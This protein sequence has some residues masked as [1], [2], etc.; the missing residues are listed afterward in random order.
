MNIADSERNLDPNPTNAPKGSREREA[1]YRWRYDNGCQ[2]FHPDDVDDVS[3]DV[4][5]RGFN[6]P[7][8][9]SERLRARSTIAEPTE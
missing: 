3:E 8:I 2:I 7:G 1:V 6:H 9:T 5:P 4:N